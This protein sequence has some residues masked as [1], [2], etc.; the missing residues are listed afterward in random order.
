VNISLKENGVVRS[1]FRCM[2]KY[3]TYFIFGDIELAVGEDTTKL[4]SAFLAWFLSQMIA[5]FTTDRNVQW[6]KSRKP[7]QVKVSAVMRDRVIR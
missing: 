5:W 2:H 1:Q 4:L 3:D 7:T 6:K